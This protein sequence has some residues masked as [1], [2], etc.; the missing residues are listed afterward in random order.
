MVNADETSWMLD[1]ISKYANSVAI[2][3]NGKE[4]TYFDLSR[5]IGDSRTKLESFGIKAGSRVALIG[6]F[7]ATSVSLIISLINLRAVVIPLTEVSAR[8]QETEDDRGTG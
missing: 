2:I 5:L 6:D 3:E 8:R 1:A 7:G 4:V